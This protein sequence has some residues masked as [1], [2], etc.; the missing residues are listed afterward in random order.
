V[1]RARAEPV[2]PRDFPAVGAALADIELQL[3]TTPSTRK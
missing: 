1:N 3:Q 2:A